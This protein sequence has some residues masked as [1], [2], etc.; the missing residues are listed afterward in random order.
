MKNECIKVVSAS[1]PGSVVSETAACVT[2]RRSK[3]GHV[4]VSNGGLKAVPVTFVTR[5]PDL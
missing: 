4:D 5:F 3:I 1:L 2:E